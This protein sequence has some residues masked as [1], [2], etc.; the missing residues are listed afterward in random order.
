[1]LWM[2]KK[3]QRRSIRGQQTLSKTKGEDSFFSS[4]A[5]QELARPIQQS[6]F[7]NTS[8]DHFFRSRVLTLA[9]NLAR[10]KGSLFVGS[11]SLVAGT[12]SC[13]SMKPTS[14]WSTDRYMT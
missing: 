9:L 8:N 6:A 7:L 11:R 3:E 1:M 13:S 12:R 10:W 2:E 4:T 5:S 14:T